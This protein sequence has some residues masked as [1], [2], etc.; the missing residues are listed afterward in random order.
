MQKFGERKMVAIPKNN[1]HYR[2]IS[3]SLKMALRML[4]GSFENLQV[5]QANSLQTNFESIFREK[6]TLESWVM[7]NYEL[8]EEDSISKISATSPK[9][10]RVGTIIDKPE[11]L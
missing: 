9:I 11:E 6:T 2:R 7:H 8:E 10:F 1:D 5:Y 4:N 3:Y